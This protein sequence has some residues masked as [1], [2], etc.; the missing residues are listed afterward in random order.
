M[1]VREEAYTCKYLR[2]S[3]V[4]TR[5]RALTCATEIF[6]NYNGLLFS[7]QQAFLACG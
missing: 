2:E 6:N 7:V 5:C 4:V 3:P 1:K